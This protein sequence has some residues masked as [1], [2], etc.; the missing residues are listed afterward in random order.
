MGAAKLRISERNQKFDFDFLL[1]THPLNPPPVRGIFV[2]TSKDIRVWN[3]V[4]ILYIFF[5]M[6]CDKISGGNYVFSPVSA[7]L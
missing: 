4:A 3:T 2:G 6:H 1:V 7:F 5:Y